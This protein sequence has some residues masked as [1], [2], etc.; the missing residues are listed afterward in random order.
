MKNLKV[1]LLIGLVAIGSFLVTSCGD[2]TPEPAGPKLNFLAGSG[3][4]SGNGDIVAGSAFKV[5]ITASHDVDIETLTITVSYD[6][7]TQVAPLNC[8]LCDTTFNS[9]SFTVDFNGTVEATPGYETWFFTVTDK[10]G[11]ATTE[12]IRL[13]RTAV[14]KDI[15]RV[16]V[17]L[18]NQN[19][20]AG[21]TLSLNN[22]QSNKLAD[23][24]A[25]S[26]DMDVIHVYDENG[27]KEFFL[28]APG[29]PKIL[30]YLPSVGDWATKNGTKFRL[31]SYGK[32]QFS[33]WADSKELLDEIGSSAAMVDELTIKEGDVIYVKPA[34]ANGR[35]CLI[36]VSTIGNP[37]NNDN[38]ITLE[39]LVEKD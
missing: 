31:T 17:N 12:S 4:T 23:A 18:G 7:G 14:P 6:G 1:K 9:T 22:V 20:S 37:G 33:T 21:S 36:L 3:Y 16:A 38:E 19:A 11:N 34:S 32:A 25:N 24:A 26:G 28:G 5:G 39:V 10:N 29:A 8:T 13:N 35:H 30:E 27:N 2:N 15:Q